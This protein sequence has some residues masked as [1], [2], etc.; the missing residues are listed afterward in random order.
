MKQKSRA[1]V[2]DFYRG[3]DDNFAQY[4]LAGVERSAVKEWIQTVDEN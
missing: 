4:S 2:A 1:V 3:F